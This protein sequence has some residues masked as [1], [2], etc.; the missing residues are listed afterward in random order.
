MGVMPVWK[1]KC[2]RG[3]GKGG[4]SAGAMLIALGVGVLMAYIIPYY[5]LVT[6]LGIALIIAGLKIITH[7]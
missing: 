4:F 3:G 7:R 1:N 2:C 5:I 6:M